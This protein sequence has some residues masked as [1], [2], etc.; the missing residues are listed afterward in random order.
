M[1][2]RVQTQPHYS[3]FVQESGNLEG[4]KPPKKTQGKDVKSQGHVLRIS[5]EV[6]ERPQ[7][8]HPALTPHQPSASS[9]IPRDFWRLEVDALQLLN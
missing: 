8:P 2:F 9:V 5:F 7:D 6:K 1:Y 3:T 4:F